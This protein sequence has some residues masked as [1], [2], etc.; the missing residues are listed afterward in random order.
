MNK[1][2]VINKIGV[3]LLMGLVS[4]ACENSLPDVP[5]AADASL[6][7]ASVQLAEDKAPD[8]PDTPNT[9][10]ALTSVSEIS[11]YATKTTHEAYGSNS[12]SRYALAGGNWSSD[13]APVINTDNGGNALLYACYPVVSSVTNRGDVNHSVAVTV[14]VTDA[15]KDFT[16]S[17]QTD[18][19]Y[20]T[21][22]TA[23]PAARTVSFTMNH[24]LAKVSF[25]VKK[26]TSVK[27]TLS[28]KEVEILS[29]TNRLQTG[30]GN[31]NLTTGNLT[32]LA[33]G[34]SLVLKNTTG[35]SLPTSLSQPNVTC[36]L[37]PMTAIESVLSFRLT[38]RVGGETSD[39]TFET[40]T[41]KEVQW[42]AGKH[43]V[44]VITVDKMKAGL[45]G[46]QIEGWQS[47][48]NQNTSIGI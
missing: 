12:L 42:Q 11:V 45:N 9:R 19:M 1:V 21:P 15:A 44:Y 46:A 6:H 26:S 2:T 36:L 34:S 14:N 16:A 32:A 48:A 22:Q 5:D 28:L 27:E 8:T 33:S 10:T 37:A 3:L 30:T 20:A 23:T 41:V 7:L 17:G 38:V 35:I 31:M 40:K 29:A 39:R 24:A 4:A 25:K 47:D 13:N 43:Y 18:Y